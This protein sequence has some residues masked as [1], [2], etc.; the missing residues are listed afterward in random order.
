MANNKKLTRSL[1]DRKIAGICG[2][3]GEYFNIDPVFFRILFLIFLLPGGVPGVVLYLVCYLIMP[4]AKNG[5]SPYRYQ[6]NY[7]NKAEKGDY[8]D[9][10][11]I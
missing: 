11:D 10:Y 8:T 2:G 7:Q 4:R 9:T 1:T 6:N 3:F 5:P